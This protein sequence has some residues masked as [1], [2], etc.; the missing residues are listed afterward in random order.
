[1]RTWDT[2]Q[3]L[4]FLRST[5]GHALYPGWL[6][7]ATTGLRRGE[8]LGLQRQD[9]DLKAGTLSVRRTLITLGH[10]TVESQPKTKKGSRRIA[11]EAAETAHHGSRRT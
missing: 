9:I 11:R 4:Q 1:M 6:L 7:S 5:R 8:E 3:L 10:R 2:R